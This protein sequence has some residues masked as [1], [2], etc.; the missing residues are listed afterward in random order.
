MTPKQAYFL[1]REVC[2][3]DLQ[4]GQVITVCNNGGRDR[5]WFVDYIVTAIDELGNV[6][7]EYRNAKGQVED[8]QSFANV[9][10]NTFCRS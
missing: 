9:V 6:F 1:T 7:T 4:V 2:T 10:T 5:R 8:T 3:S